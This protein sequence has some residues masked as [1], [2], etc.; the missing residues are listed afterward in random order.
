MLL[1]MVVL[2][3]EGSQGLLSQ[4]FLP[5][6][7][8]Q[9][10]EDPVA[11][12]GRQPMGPRRN[13]AALTPQGAK[14]LQSRTLSPLSLAPR[15]PPA[16]PSPPLGLTLLCSHRA[17]KGAAVPRGSQVDLFERGV[18]CAKKMPLK[19]MLQSPTCA[20]GGG[21]DRTWGEAACAS[22]CPREMPSA[23]LTLRGAAQLMPTL[24]PFPGVMPLLTTR[25]GCHLP[26]GGGGLCHYPPRL[27]QLLAC[28]TKGMLQGV[29]KGHAWA[30]GGATKATPLPRG[31]FQYTN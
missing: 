7:P 15:R 1:K 10:G 9:L 30:R 28:H 17:A 8:P 26:R 13:Q 6:R 20:P 31:D 22:S 25:P 16:Q 11:A 27:A 23:S 5:L 4:G 24:R 3:G 29:E 18:K 21:G 2:H 12:Q 19:M 14:G